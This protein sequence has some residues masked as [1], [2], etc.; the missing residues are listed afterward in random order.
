MNMG[1]K[2]QRYNVLMQ[3]VTSLKNTV[4]VLERDQRKREASIMREVV[5]GISKEMD[6]LSAGIKE[7]VFN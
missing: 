2:I 6:R 4:F 5:L 1:K 3:S 7:E